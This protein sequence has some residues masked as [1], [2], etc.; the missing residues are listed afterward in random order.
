MENDR[1][2]RLKLDNGVISREY[3]LSFLI[4]YCEDKIFEDLNDDNGG[5]DGS[6]INESVSFC[7]CGNIFDDNKIVEIMWD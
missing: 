4:E 6:C 1:K 5:C 7:E 2:I 3:N